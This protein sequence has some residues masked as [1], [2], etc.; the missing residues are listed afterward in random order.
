[1][2]VPPVGLVSRKTFHFRFPL[3]TGNRMYF[4]TPNRA[5]A[6]LPFILAAVGMFGATLAYAPS[7]HAQAAASTQGRA[8]VTGTV[9]DLES[10]QPLATANIFIVGTPITAVTGADGRFVIPSAPAG[11]YTIE[12][13]RLGHGSQRFENVRLVADSVH[14]F[15]FTLNNTPLMMDQ[16]TVSGTMNETSVAKSTISVAK[17]TEADIPVPTTASA[18][19]MV[20]G[21]VAGVN[22]VRPSGAPGSGVNIVLRTPISGVTQEGSVPGPLFVVDGVFLNSTQQVTTQDMEAM[23]VESIEVIKGAAAASLYGARAAAGVIAITTRRGKNLALGTQQFQVRSE[24]GIDQFQYQLEKNQH[25]QFIQ[26]QQGNWLNAAGAI[27]P[28]HQRVVK[29]LGMMDSPYYSPTYDQA[30][31]FF[32][33]GSYRKN[34]LTVQGN[35]SNTNYNMTYTRDDNPGV[36]PNNQ[37]FSRQSIRVNV[38]SRLSEKLTL[39]LSMNHSRANTDE[40]AV[41]FGD[42]FRIDT[43]INLKEPDPFP[44]AGF[45]Y[46]IIPDSVTNY[47]N[48]LFL[49]YI[50]NNR[51]SRA[52]TLIAANGSYRPWNWLSLSA[53]ANYDRGDLRNKAYTPRGTPTNSSG[54]L[55]FSTGR[56]YLET[57]IVDGYRMTGTASLTKGI[58]GLTIRLSERGEVQRES[59]P[60]TTATGTDFATEGVETMAQARTKAATSSFTDRRTIGA[61]TNLGLSYNEK[62]IGDF[63]IR[64]EGNSLF[65]RANRWNTFGR[66]SAAWVV[67]E[68]GWFP[69]ESFNTFKIRYSYGVTGLSPNF[70]YQYEAMSSDGTGGLTRS[71]LGNVD[72]SPTF[73]KEEELGI[74]LSYKSRLSGSLVYVRNASRDV[75][76]AVP[77]LAVSGYQTVVRNTATLTG[78]IT[79]A[80]IQGQILNNP[81]GLQW[82]ALIVADR[83]NSYIKKFGRTCFADGIQNKCEN[84]RLSEMWGNRMVT[85]KSQLLQRHANSGAQFDVNDEGYV[86]AVGTGNTWR[87]GIA[88]NLW[89]TTVTID[90]T[91]YPWGRPI[92][93]RQENNQAVYQKIGDSQADMNFGFNNTF[94]YKDVR[95]YF[96]IAGQLGG[97][98]YSRTNQLF[99]QSGDHNDVD[100]FGRPD[101]LKKPVAYYN[102]LTN[103]STTAYLENF[104][105]SATYASLNEFLV[106]YTFDSRKYGFLKRVGMD[107][108]QVDLVGRNLHIFTNYTGL[109]VRGGS[110][111]SRI[112]ATGYPLTRTWSGVVT[113]TF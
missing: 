28:R 15:S 7:V 87:D 3:C 46:K 85:D 72:V 50:S 49:S 5:R 84:S 110:S 43:D 54:T 32:K 10:K 36:V 66:A 97:N 82:T 81:R 112:D 96:Q 37:G 31:D 40:I 8:R 71:Q 111:T 65:G 102:A 59:N 6:P 26:D 107:R 48:P 64:R 88:K 23:D 100:Q 62:Y 2:C 18:A 108:A 44:K 4:R 21:K 83:S 90:G 113:L 11:I 14:T 91:A 93:Q 101:E 76:V 1:M 39:G 109:N 57:D 75:F 20:Q 80:T 104:V 58:G 29:P 69:F 92:L 63:L 77:A 79:E 68:E 9:V 73:T 17:V 105:E 47:T 78:N 51:T 53:E 89:G 38:D 103:N 52:R 86:V 33:A 41:S 16:V 70:S 61:I 99:Y 74:D 98:V 24:W 42:F 34:S 95:L 55:G 60:Y 67:S 106:G 13:K 35:S 22:I 94:R 56:L 45:P 30:N 25:H 12:A 27:V 19:S